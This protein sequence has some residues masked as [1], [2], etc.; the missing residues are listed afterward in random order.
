MEPVETLTPGCNRDTVRA[1]RL[2]TLAAWLLMS[3]PLAAHPLFWVRMFRSRLLLWHYA[4]LVTLPVMAAAAAAVLLL[5]GLRDIKRNCASF[6]MNLLLILSAAVLLLQ[7][8]VRS[9]YTGSRL[10]PE[11]WFLPLLPLAGMALSRE[12]MR[13]LP[14]WG[15]FVL[16]VLIVFTVRFPFFIGLPGNWNWNLSLLACLLPA[17]FLL[18]RLKSKQFWIPVLAAAVFLGVFS[19]FRPELAPFGVMIGAVTASAA[20]WLLWK[21]PRRQRLFITILGGGAGVAMFLAIWLGPADSANRDSRIWLWRGSVELALRRGALGIGSGKFEREIEPYLPKEYYFS[22]FAASLH[23]HPHNEL[24]ATW[25]ASGVPGVVSLMLL[26]LAAVA[27]LRNASSTRVWGFWLFLVLS[28]HGQ[29]D[30]L[31]QTPLA[32]SLWLIVGGALAGDGRSSEEVHPWRGL[33]GALAAAAFTG[34]TFM[35]SWY[36]RDG[37]LSYLAKDRFIALKKLEKS[38]ALWETSSARYVAGKIEL[39]LRNPRSAV[40][41]F[42]KLSPGY[43]HSNLYMGGA[44]ADM[45]EYKVALECLDVEAKAF[46]MSALNV[47]K[48]LE[49]MR[50]TGEDEASLASRETRLKYL[51]RLRGVS[52]EELLANHDLDD[53]PL[54]NP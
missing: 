45:G 8:V 17:P 38:L 31:L 4:T 41:H 30:V 37:M 11:D 18:F 28:V 13:I 27:G 16:A 22:N 14:R 12:I 51:L 33:A 46:P 48:Q 32:G 43:L 9:I 47:Y 21:L 7:S 40:R 24:L 50:R 36:Y 34:V 49:I 26:T 6:R 53:R 44:Y 52:L 42:E 25:C 10:E 19:A 5:T 39:Q 15:T 35:S 23:P 1:E 20:L 2:K 29:V 54:R 3:L